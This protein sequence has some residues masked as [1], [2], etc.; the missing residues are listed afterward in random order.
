MDTGI[1]QIK[2]IHENEREYITAI[3]K[4]C[5]GRVWGKGGAAEV[6]DIPPTTLKSR[7]KKL[8]IEKRASNR[9]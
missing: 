1:F 6:L 3:L 7:M 9:H 5:N 4:K 8:G 2:T